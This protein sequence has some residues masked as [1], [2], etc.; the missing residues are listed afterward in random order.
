MVRRGTSAAY[1]LSERMTLTKKTAA[2]AVLSP[3]E[4]MLKFLLGALGFV[5]YRRALGPLRSPSKIDAAS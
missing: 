3:W 2:I 4:Q 5:E 1:K